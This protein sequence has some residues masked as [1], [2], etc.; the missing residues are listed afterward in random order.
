MLEPQ[1]DS[2]NTARK[3]VLKSGIF[4]APKVGSRKRVGSGINFSALPDSNAS[5]TFM[6]P[7]IPDLGLVFG[8][9]AETDEE[10]SMGEN[11]ICVGDY[12]AVQ[13]PGVS[14][15]F[16][17]SKSDIFSALEWKKHQGNPY[18]KGARK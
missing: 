6:F 1:F 11:T 9:I 17:S 10:A 14:S 15:V 18:L 3:G 4:G 7:F 8:D 16:R 5:S 13:H 2:L 12:R